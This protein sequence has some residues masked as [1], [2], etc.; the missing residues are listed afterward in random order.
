M[1]NFK[2][3]SILL[4]FLTKL[5]FSS[6]INW[7]KNYDEALN[8]SKTSSKPLVVLF[9]Q[10]G[11]SWCSKLNHEILYNSDFVKEVNDKFIFCRLY[12]KKSHKRTSE[13]M[14]KNYELKEKFKIK[15]FPILI[16]E[17]PQK[18]LISTLGYLPISG[19]KYAKKLINSVN[20]CKKI[21]TA[22]L[23]T[24]VGSDQEKLLMSLYKKSKKIGCE[25]FENLFYEEG[26]KTSQAI[27]FLMDRYQTIVDKGQYLS[28]EGKEIRKQIDEIKNFKQKEIELKLALIDFQSLAKINDSDEAVQ[29]LIKYIEA[30]GKKDKPNL[31]RLR[32]IIA[33]YYLSKG[34]NEKALEYARASY[35]AAPKMVKKEITNTILHMKDKISRI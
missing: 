26:I 4:I 17:D 6:E 33:Q 5:A 19:K 35:K 10:E 27:N 23:K 30:Y 14:Q 1:K 34:D 25:Y 20:E 16:V 31:W 3:F 29:P 13:E 18:G 22:F 32:M 12:F 24:K 15:G 9:T 28:E 11:C 2:I 7:Y 21:E 8:E